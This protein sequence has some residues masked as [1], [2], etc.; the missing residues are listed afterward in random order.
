MHT[1]FWC[2]NLEEKYHLQ[3]L[4]VRCKHC[5]K[6]DVEGALGVSI[7]LKWMLKELGG[8]ELD[9]SGLG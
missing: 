7:V 1:G 3:E 5:I 4:G 8:P 2:G 9:S 6:M